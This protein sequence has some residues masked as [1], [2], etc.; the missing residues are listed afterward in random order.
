MLGYRGAFP[1][2]IQTLLNPAFPIFVQTFL[3]EIL[4]SFYSAE[5]R[6][7]P[8]FYRKRIPRGQKFQLL[9]LKLQ[10]SP[11]IT[12]I[13]GLKFFSELKPRW[14]P[15]PETTEWVAQR[16]KRQN[17]AQT[18]SCSILRAPEGLGGAWLSPESP[19]TDKDPI[20]SAT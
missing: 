14:V 18:R 16:Q 2:Q 4:N 11:S 15:G 8:K 1:Y 17:R 19:L 5:Q 13:Q 9:P 6:K 20:L 12:I 7:K 3:P 10:Y